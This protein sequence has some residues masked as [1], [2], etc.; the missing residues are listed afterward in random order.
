MDLYE[1]TKQHIK[2]KDIIQKKLQHITEEDNKIVCQYKDKITTFLP[3]KELTK[4]A[5]NDNTTIVCDNTKANVEQLFMQWNLF[6]KPEHLIII[7]V[8][9]NTNKKWSIC[10]HTH[11]KISERTHLKKG[12]LALYEHSKE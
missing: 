3:T 10:P 12:L 8:D 7:F 4:I 6:S 9:T 2:H 11:D 1:W 5:P